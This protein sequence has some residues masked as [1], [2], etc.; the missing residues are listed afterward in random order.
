LNAKVWAE[1]QILNCLKFN[2]KPECHSAFLII[3]I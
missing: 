3:T 2:R 1:T